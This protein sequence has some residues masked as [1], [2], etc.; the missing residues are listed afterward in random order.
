MRTNIDL[1]DVLVEEAM[2]L[3]KATTKK[4]VVH[5][6]LKEFVANKRRKDLRDLRGKISFA[7]DYDYKTLRE[8]A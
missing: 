8:S 6:A 1:D 7:P 2:R 5:Q 4:E 3:S